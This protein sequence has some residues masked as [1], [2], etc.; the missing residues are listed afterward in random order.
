MDD[1][2]SVGAD[3]EL[4]WLRHAVLQNAGFKVFTT[5]DESDAMACIRRC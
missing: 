3:Q 5:M 1:V 2:L 4:L